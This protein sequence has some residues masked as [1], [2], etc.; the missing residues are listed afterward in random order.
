[1]TDPGFT[2]E[3]KQYLDGFLS[4][5]AVR[6]GDGAP[7]AGGDRDRY[8]RNRHPSCSARPLHR[9]G[10]EARAR[11]RGEAQSAS[12]R[13]V[14]RVACRSRRGPLPQRH[15]RLSSQI[16]RPVLCRAGAGFIHVPAAHPERRASAASDDRPRRARRAL[17]P[18]ATPTSRRAPISSFAR[19]SRRASSQMLEGLQDLGLTSRGA[20]ADNI[21]NITGSPTAGIDPQELIDTRPLTRAAASLHPQSS[22]ALRPAAQIQHRLRW[23]RRAYRCSKTPT[24]SAS[25]R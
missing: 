21:R 15:R 3:Q 20:G 22:R 23:R 24:I 14:G 5:I 7:G 25:P 9:C 8:S 6:R 4:G 12:A 16:L 11:G 17:G 1:M 10:Q 13:Y 18:A 2:D 19:S